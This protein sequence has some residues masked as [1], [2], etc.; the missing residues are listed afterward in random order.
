MQLFLGQSNSSAPPS[1]RGAVLRYTFSLVTVSLALLL[2][3]WVPA[4]RSGTPFVFFFL[5]VALSA[6]YGGLRP[7]LFAVAL[8]VLSVNLWVFP[9]SFALSSTL[10]QAIQMVVFLAVAGIIVWL[11]Y[12]FQQTQSRLYV[13][14][15][16][17][18]LTLTSIGDAVIVTDLNEKVSWMNDVAASVTGWSAAEAA[19]RPLT[20]VFPIVNQQTRVPVE[21]P[22][23]RVLAEGK[24]IGL[25]N[26]TV[27]LAKDGVERPIE[28]SAAPIRDKVGNLNG[29]VLVFR[30]VTER[31]QA[32]LATARLAQQVQQ[33]QERLAGLIANVPGVV[34]EAWG[35]PDARTQRIDFVSDY[36]ESLLGYSKAEWLA[37]SNFWLSIVHPDD[38]AA[39]AKGCRRF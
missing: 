11:V 16:A 39:A 27:L 1:K 34:W 13:E 15:Q 22:V 10:A 4:I 18:H 2:T 37:V 9:S 12:V 5:A 38:K 28:D 30:D 7:G 35:Q 19:G 14:R 6:W 31:R 26:H 36:V 20:E 21:N 33:E 3:L 23:R 25:A 17:L 29:V 24:I 8:G 32:E